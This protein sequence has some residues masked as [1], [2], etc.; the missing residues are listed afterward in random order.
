MRNIKNIL[1]SFN[2][3]IVNCKL[4]DV[5]EDMLEHFIDNNLEEGLLKDIP[6]IG[7]L[8]GIIQ[9]TQNIS[10]YLF[11]RKILAFISKIK[12][13][14]P[15]V[16]KQLILSIDES[17]EY[18]EKVGTTLLS[19]IDKSESPEKAE[20]IAILFRAFLKK[21]INYECF[22]YGSHI[23]QRCYLNDFK[24]FIQSEET[25]K[26][27]EDSTDEIMSGL[28]QLNISLA[29]MGYKDAIETKLKRE[30]DYAVAGITDIGIILRRVF[31]KAEKRGLL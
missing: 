16:R 4:T 22:L 26:M 3:T 29:L 23:I 20:Y 5:T 21:E 10:N 15:K 12:D 19:I 9:T 8:V 24:E 11:L 30:L 2:N 31:N 6:I 27:V 1:N 13:V 18:R 14:S 28:Y 17:E 7:T 25:W